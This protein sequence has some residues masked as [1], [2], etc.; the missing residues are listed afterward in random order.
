MSHKYIKI[1]LAVVLGAI[2]AV[3]FSGAVAST[4]VP[5]DDPKYL[6]KTIDIDGSTYRTKLLDDKS[7]EVPD[8]V[9]LCSQYDGSNNLIAEDTYVTDKHGIASCALMG[10][11]IRVRMEYAPDVFVEEKVRKQIPVS[12]PEA[13]ST[14]VAAT[15]VTAGVV[16]N[17]SLVMSGMGLK[18][19]LLLISNY[20]FLLFGIKK[21]KKFGVVYDASTQKPVAGAIVQLYEADRMRQIGVAMTD[22]DGGYVFTARPG[23]YV[24]SVTKPGFSFPS[25]LIQQ[26]GGVGNSYIGQ[27]IEV[28]QNN[29]G[30]NYLIPID[31]FAGD[32]VRIS[33]FRRIAS[34][35]LVRYA[36]L[37]SG[38]ATSIYSLTVSL[39]VM[40]YVC[41]SAFLILWIAELSNLNRT[42]KYSR[43]ME[44]HGRKPIELALVR[45][46]NAD[47]K[48]V[49]TFVTDQNGRVLPKITQQGQKIL[50]EK[51][52]YQNAEYSTSS[53]GMIEKRIFEVLQ[54]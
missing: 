43:V 12:V 17:A 22:R 23:R 9:L 27:V 1:C 20:F 3:R 50:I 41:I 53:E 21:K 5:I 37:I 13:A 11:T 45:V 46:V 24:L 51:A 54:R 39:G 44:N 14:V 34:S 26:A 30:I 36:L 8:S 42:I 2:L 49:E 16:S 38:T 33:V 40:S 29:P 19:F 25:K 48:L 6:L 4:M 47:G 32:T 31:P 18:D 28:G 52:G 7:Q 35:L 15:V 10:E